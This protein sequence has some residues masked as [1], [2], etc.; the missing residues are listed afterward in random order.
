MHDGGE[1][2]LDLGVYLLV[3]LFDPA[4]PTEGSDGDV[5]VSLQIGASMT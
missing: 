1:L 5:G 2:V 3:L 4:S